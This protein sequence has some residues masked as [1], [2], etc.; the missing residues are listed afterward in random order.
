MSWVRV[1][2]PQP[3]LHGDKL[4]N[5][6]SSHHYLTLQNNVKNNYHD[7]IVDLN[8]DLVGGYKSAFFSETFFREIGPILKSND[9]K[10]FSPDHLHWAH[11]FEQLITI[12]QLHEEAQEARKS[13][14][15]DELELLQ[16][17]IFNFWNAHE[18][19]HLF[20]DFIQQGNEP[21]GASLELIPL[22]E[23]QLL[24]F[25]Y[26]HLTKDPFVSDSPL[27]YQ[28][29]PE[30]GDGDLGFRI[31]DSSL[32]A[33]FDLKKANGLISFSRV[34]HQQKILEIQNSEED[35]FLVNFEKQVPRVQSEGVELNY[36]AICEKGEKSA[37][38]NIK[39]LK[40]ALSI[41]R[42]FS[43]DCFSALK[44][45]THSI[46]PISDQGIVS[47]SLQSLPGYSSINLF[48]RD[49]IDLLD[50]LVHENGHHY[51]NVH[52]NHSELIIEDD[53]DIF[54][55]PW[56]RSFR[57]IRGLYH[58]YL[59]FA[60][61]LKLFVD[62]SLNSKIQ[63]V[64]SKKEIS[65]IVL[66]ALEEFEMLCFCHS[67][68][69]KAYRLKKITG[70]GMNLY[71]EFRQSVEGAQQDLNG[72]DGHLF[73]KDKKELDELRAHLTQIAAKYKL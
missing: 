31:G 33:S 35:I 43:P 53:E 73:D 14:Q 12:I 4:K 55:S 72:L 30:R 18:H 34:D 24:S 63:S 32:L 27:I 51:L 62:I 65:K 38:R 50:D 49:N 26:L 3:L 22:L 39:R 9:L 60:W 44:E 66:R 67:Q 48:D 45:F 10:N 58:A 13:L 17:D 57:P 23:N 64:F 46:I 6:A 1:P 68:I 71:R 8:D 15:N 70:E 19:S 41:I 36:L 20:V 37:D 21:E 16:E 25:Y 11:C 56:R 47:F 69:E 40:E 7:F 2:P 5:L 61:A 29:I 54:Y 28:A 52:L 59:T 42:E